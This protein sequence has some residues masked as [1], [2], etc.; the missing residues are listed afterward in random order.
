MAAN[1]NFNQ[2]TAAALAGSTGAKGY[3]MYGQ[4]IFYPIQDLGFTAGYERRNA[5]NYAS[6]GNNFEK[7]NTNIYA[8]VAYDLNAAVRVAAEYQNLNTQYGHVTNG[9]GNLAGLSGTG[10]ANIA[11][12]AVYYF[13]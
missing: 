7:S 1:M 4:V 3:G 13:F 10:T 5:S 9:A 12:M 11:R 8:N 2:A 6:F